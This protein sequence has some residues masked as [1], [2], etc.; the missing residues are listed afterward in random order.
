MKNHHEVGHFKYRLM[1]GLLS[2]AAVTVMT[3]QSFAATTCRTCHEMP[4]LDSADG[5]RLPST[6]AFKG[7]HKKHMGASAEPAECTKCHGNSGYTSNHAAL[8]GNMIQI[9]SNINGSFGGTYSKTAFPT[10]V[11]S[12]SSR[13]LLQCELSL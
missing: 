1:I 12:R 2:L 13:Q 8:S 4:P 6:G 5:S 11:N 7:S 9:N 10:N 3:G